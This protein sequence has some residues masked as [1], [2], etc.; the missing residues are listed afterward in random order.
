MINFYKFEKNKWNFI[1]SQA[2]Q[3]DYLDFYKYVY[4][5]EFPN[6]NDYE[7]KIRFDTFDVN[8]DQVIDVKEFKEAARSTNWIILFLN[9]SI[10]TRISIC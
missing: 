8:K 2:D 7:S 1:S 6:Y 10:W 4:S 3:L 5:E 9:Q